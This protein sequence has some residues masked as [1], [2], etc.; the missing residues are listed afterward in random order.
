MHES[1]AAE[2]ESNEKIWIVDNR[3]NVTM[4]I[5]ENA[6]NPNTGGLID[7]GDVIPL[8]SFNTDTA[9]WNYEGTEPVTRTPEE[10]LQV[11]FDAEHLSYWNLDFYTL[12]TCDA[13][14]NVD[15][16]SVV[17]A[18]TGDV[19]VNVVLLGSGNN[20]GY[21]RDEMLSSRTP[22]TLQGVSDE[23]RL[24][25]RFESLNPDRIVFRTMSLNGEP[26]SGQEVDFC[27]PNNFVITTNGSDNT[28]ATLFK[29]DYDVNVR[30]RCTNAPNAATQPL[31]N[32]HTF[33]SAVAGGTYVT[34]RT[35]DRG[36]S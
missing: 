28:L 36:S 26:Y 17:G 34:D 31:P 3:P 18:N 32:V 30:A 23:L 5:P 7:E 9:E 11:A 4:T 6:E 2:R 13:R 35:N 8:W 1:G 10:E 15:I 12:N 33:F 14:I 16:I 22:T 27:G 24:T 20:I 19:P 29:F 25:A 21:R